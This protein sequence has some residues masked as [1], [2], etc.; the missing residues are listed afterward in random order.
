MGR[1]NWPFLKYYILIKGDP[2]EVV[3]NISIH[4]EY[5]NEGSY[6]TY[7]IIVFTYRVR[8]GKDKFPII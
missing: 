5:P 8:I 2:I 3:V 4:I 7:L 1:F 6:T